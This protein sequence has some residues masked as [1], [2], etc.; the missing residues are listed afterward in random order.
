VR[1]SSDQR[2]AP[3]TGRGRAAVVFALLAAAPLAAAAGLR[4]EGL[5]RLYFE[6]IDAAN[7]AWKHAAELSVLLPAQLEAPQQVEAAA[8]DPDAEFRV[9]DVVLPLPA[10]T[11]PVWLRE[12]EDA[13]HPRISSLWWALYEGGVRREVW[14][15]SAIPARTEGKLLGNYA[16]ESVGTTAANDL[17]LRLRSRMLR[18]G[19]A[20]WIAGRELTLRVAGDAITLAAVLTPFAFTRGYD[21]GED[22]GSLTVASERRVEAGIEL[23]RRDD[24][25]ESLVVACGLRDRE[26]A[27]EDAPAWSALEQAAQ[28]IISGEGT[29][30]VTRAAAE[31]GFAE[32]TTSN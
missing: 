19:G 17:V 13:R 23:R 29:T 2:R 15:Y 8:L 9:R 7:A 21:S 1:T 3:A 12:V 11:A 28:C 5:E 24:V 22:V 10:R 25:G 16:V 18:P 31:P 27:L 32:R 14:F 30:I 4:F 26:A 20:W 6:R